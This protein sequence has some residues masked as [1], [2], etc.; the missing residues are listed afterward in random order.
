M[1][2]WFEANIWLGTSIGWQNDQLQKLSLTKPL[3]II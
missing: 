3:E 1:L 2:Q